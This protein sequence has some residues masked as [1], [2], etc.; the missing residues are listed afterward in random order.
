LLALAI[1]LLN[2][3]P[4]RASGGTEPDG[5]SPPVIETFEPAGLTTGSRTIWTV[6]GRHLARVDRVELE[7][8]GVRASVVEADDEEVTLLAEAEPGVVVGFRELRLAGPNGV[9]NARVVRVDDLPQAPEREP[10]DTPDR[11]TRLEPETAAVGT[12]RERDVDHF[13]VAGRK[14]RRLVVEVEARRLGAPVAPVI[15]LA[16]AA[17]RALTQ[18]RATPGLAG[19]ALLVLDPPDDADYIIQVRDNLYGGAPGAS[20][21]LRVSSGPF[22][23]ALYPLGGAPGATLSVA[24][25]GGNLPNPT[26]RTIHLPDNPGEVVELGPFGGRVLAP[27]RLIVG[28]GHEAGGP[29]LD[30]APRRL[31]P[32]ESTNGRLE[33]VGIPDRFVIEAGAGEP[34]AVR[35]IAAPLGSRLDG[36]LTVRDAAGRVLA[37]NDDAGANALPPLPFG[38]DGPNPDPRLVVS[39]PARQDLTV[40]VADRYSRAGPEFAYRLDAGPVVPDFR[41]TFLHEESGDDVVTFRPG[42]ETRLALRVDRVGRTGPIAV[43]AEGLPAG[44]VSPSVV[45][46]GFSAPVGATATDMTTARVVLVLR[47]APEARAGWGRLGVVATATADDGRVLTRRGE[48]P[49]TVSTVTPHGRVR[50]VARGATSVP[51]WVYIG[52]AAR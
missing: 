18:S 20:Y 19:D 36:V 35:L 3:G 33:R 22:A 28:Q 50:T 45:A 31:R 15:S 8:V 9:S 49:L 39:V 2:T 1:V 37:E 38:I 26:T 10:N 4:L 11:A 52:E 21:R 34:L 16:T 51:F 27:G 6:R 47:V 29:S 14:G 5:P 42:R 44:V 43:R 23:T 41:V 25:S 32:G 46:R 24:A 13:R 12:L 17:G 30:G 40:E 48:R 7:G